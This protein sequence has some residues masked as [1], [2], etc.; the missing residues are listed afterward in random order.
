M[1]QRTKSEIWKIRKQE[2]PNQNS[3]EKKE[4]EGSI[5]SLWDNFKHTN[6]HNLEVP[7]E[8]RARN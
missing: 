1:K 7:E 5:R 6:I 4:F 3:K 8:E 2:T